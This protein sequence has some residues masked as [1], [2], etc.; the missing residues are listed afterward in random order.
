MDR[1]SIIIPVLLPFIDTIGRSSLLQESH[2]CV[3]V[4]SNM[5]A[6]NKC[7]KS[8]HIYNFAVAYT[9]DSFFMLK[10]IFQKNIQSN[11]YLVGLPVMSSDNFFDD[12]MS[13]CELKGLFIFIHTIIWVFCTI[14]FQVLSKQFQNLPVYPQSFVTT[15]LFIN[16]FTCFCKRLHCNYAI[17]NRNT[18]KGIYILGRE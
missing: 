15:I 4:T 16:Y 17:V 13:Y 1:T 10:N 2:A 3:I 12:N 8:T 11:S 7:L 14:L 9:F 6:F 18:I 5:Y